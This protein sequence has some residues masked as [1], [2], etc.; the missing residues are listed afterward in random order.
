M[1][2]YLSICIYMRDDADVSGGGDERLRESV[3]M[4][5]YTDI[6][7]DRWINMCIYIC[8]NIHTSV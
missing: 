7:I 3:H 2:A 6:H 4:E 1:H 8:I 5:I